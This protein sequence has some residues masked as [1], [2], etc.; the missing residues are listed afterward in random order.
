MA[1]DRAKF[2]PSGN[3]ASFYAEGHKHSA[4]APKWL[5]GLG[6]DAYEYSFGRGVKLSDD[7]AKEIGEEARKYGVALSVHAPYYINF[8]SESAETREKSRQYLLDSVRSASIMRAERVV[9][10]AGTCSGQ[11]RAAALARTM[12]ELEVVLR[13]MTATEADYVMICP[14]TMGRP[15][16]QG[17]LE[18]VLE[19]CAINPSMLLPAIDFG[20]I[21]ALGHGSL[22]TRKDYEQIVDAVQKSLGVRSARRMHV[23]FSHIE[24]GPSGEIKHLT[25]ED[26]AFGPD[27]A[28]LAQ[29]FAERAMRPVV[30]CESRDVMAEDALTLKA[31]YEKALLKSGG[32]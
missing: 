23:H 9:F 3:S 4:Q 22:K 19:M 16:Q 25:L 5:H 24:Y 8:A 7:K 20:H 14:E 18:E 21:N 29:V 26:E 17:T 27:F 1:S 13:G 15:S 32:V 10:H 6:L 12:K 31:A 30:I 2:G 28:P 11:D